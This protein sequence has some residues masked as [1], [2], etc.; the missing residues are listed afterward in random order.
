MTDVQTE[1]WV[2]IIRGGDRVLIRPLHSQDAEME[3]RFIEALSPVARRFR[4]LET[5]KT[6]SEA[7]LK[8]LTVLDPATDA[9]F[10]AVTVTGSRE[11]PIGVGRFSADRGGKDCEFAVTVADAWQ[12]KGLGTLLM[13]HL[14]ATARQR[15]LRNMYSSDAWDNELM[16][17]FAAHMGL[18]HEPDPDDAT[19]VRYSLDLKPLPPAVNT[20]AG[21]GAAR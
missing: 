19:Q 12:Q 2:R 21:P 20:L 10:V 4:F 13:E 11:A 6:P 9:A 5:M 7:L 3:R 17:R 16:R 8:Q 1:G 18:R 14:I 15:G